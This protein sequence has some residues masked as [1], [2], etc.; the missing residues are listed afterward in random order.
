MPEEAVIDKPKNQNKS[1]PGRAGRPPKLA[2]QSKSRAERDPLTPVE[3]D[4]SLESGP[5][6]IQGG[7]VEI[8]K[9]PHFRFGTDQPAPRRPEHFFQW[10]D[11]LTVMEKRKVIVYVYRNYP[12]IGVKVEDR[13]SPTGYRM[14]SQ[15]DK[16]SGTDVLRSLDDILHHYGSGNYTIRLNQADPNKAVCLCIIQG[17]RD[18][19]H[20]PVVDLNTLLI[21]DP[22]NKP[23]IEGLRL[24]GVR[25]PG[26][27]GIN[28]E[29]QVGAAAL[30]EMVG[31]VGKLMD[32]NAELSAKVANPPREE[33][34]PG[35]D[36][37]IVSTALATG[38]KI[39]S[40]ASDTQSAMLKSAMDKVGELS[41][42]AAPP[43][44]AAAPDP[45]AMLD[46]VGN[47][48]RSLSP[49]PAGPPLDKEGR[50][51]P[52]SLDVLVAASLQRTTD[53]E[54]RLHETQTQQMSFLQ[55][56]ILESRKAPAAPS[57]AMQPTQRQAAEG[58]S[59]TPA[60]PLEMLREL[61][62]LKEGL[63]NL[64]GD[65]EHGGEPASR[66]NPGAPWWASLLQ[67]LPQLIQGGA[68]IASMIAVASYNNAIAKTGT[69]Q[70]TPVAM[71]TIQPPVE[72]EPSDELPP[73]PPSSGAETNLPQPGDTTLNAYHHFLAQLEKPLLL[74]LE[75]N[76][77]GDQFA[78][79]LV[80]WQGQVAYDL[81]HGLGRDQVIQILST[82]RPIWSVVSTIP[83]KFSQFLDEFLS[84]GD[85]EQPP[86][87]PP[88]PPPPAPPN[89]PRT[90]AAPP[91]VDAA[92]VGGKAHN[93]RAGKAHKNPTGPVTQ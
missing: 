87:F 36:E 4:T 13:K 55:N 33:K 12:V 1:H 58:T 31:T 73:P 32:R 60:T 37:S 7:R 90:Q 64:T 74:A 40:N 59:A 70:P 22:Q 91:V 54:R 24:R 84:Y 83:Q 19:Q 65:G 68:A 30:S 14:S 29:D 38:M 2:Q 76:E 11:G 18:E 63:G 39:I 34:K 72:T 81:L 26:V 9:P 51:I 69:G 3:G 8:P 57:T 20:P 47:L 17:L 6:Y 46:K 71:P 89:Q 42:T 66:S 27:D 35:A 43:A 56:M 16:R 49:T 88:A 62:K 25:V 85:Q 28:E 48:L 50:P 41:K 52:S 86:D 5:E 77:P 79:K 44:A 15:I 80:G 21:D 67:S 82:Y 45:L 78:E 53:L 93:P 10:W 75:N 23:Y 92:G 61:V